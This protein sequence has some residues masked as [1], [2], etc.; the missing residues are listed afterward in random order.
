MWQRNEDD[1]N[2]EVLEWKFYG[3]KTSR[4]TKKIWLYA[5]EKNLNRIGVQKWKEL[6]GDR[7]KWRDLVTEVEI[8]KEY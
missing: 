7:E 3:G 8:L 1:I 4:T 2:R 5:V 6:D